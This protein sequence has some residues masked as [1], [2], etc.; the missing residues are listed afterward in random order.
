[1]NLPEHQ[2]KFKEIDKE[3]RNILKLDDKSKSDVFKY[4]LRNEYYQKVN[5]ELKANISNAVLNACKNS[6]DSV[7][8]K[9][10]KNRIKNNKI[11]KVYRTNPKFQTQRSSPSREYVNNE[12]EYHKYSKSKINQFINY[13]MQIERENLSKVRADDE[14]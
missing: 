1:M 7:N 6:P 13:A 3:F 2:A 9:E 8:E 11:Q 10:K 14:K 12:K 4:Q 5:N